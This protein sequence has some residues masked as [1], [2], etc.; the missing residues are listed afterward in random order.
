[1]KNYYIVATSRLQVDVANPL[2]TAELGA[3]VALANPDKLQQI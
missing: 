1:M 2:C 3:F